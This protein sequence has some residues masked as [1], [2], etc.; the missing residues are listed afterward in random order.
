M[1]HQLFRLGNTQWWIL[2]DP[3]R[4]LIVEQFHKSTLVK[5]IK[6]IQDTLKTKPDPSQ[7]EK[8]LQDAIRFVSAADA[9]QAVKQRV[10][11]LIEDMFTAYQGVPDILDTVRLRERLSRLQALLAEMDK[12]YGNNNLDR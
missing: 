11:R 5:T 4:D 3:E 6:S 10:N 9:D 12:T 2:F 8:D 1:A 7:V